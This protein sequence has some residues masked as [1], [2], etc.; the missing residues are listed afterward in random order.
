MKYTSQNKTANSKAAKVISI[1]ENRNLFNPFN[2]K[3]FIENLLCSYTTDNRVA[4]DS[5]RLNTKVTKN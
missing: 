2:L 1:K 5:A 4:G 3:P